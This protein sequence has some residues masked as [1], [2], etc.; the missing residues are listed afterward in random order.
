M[1]WLQ[2][3]PVTFNRST[4]GWANQE[5]RLYQGRMYKL[6]T[7]YTV[8]GIVSFS[9]EGS[10]LAPQAG[11]PLWDWWLQSLG[12][13]GLGI[14]FHQFTQSWLSP[15]GLTLSKLARDP[16]WYTRISC[17]FAEKMSARVLTHT[18]GLLFS[19]RRKATWGKSDYL[20]HKALMS[21]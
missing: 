12:V 11:L 8:C 13:E 1:S 7:V 10:Q 20:L 14:P 2:T 17:I 18:S 4:W 6:F 3:R 5:V 19:I 9:Q 16:D 15:K 21:Q